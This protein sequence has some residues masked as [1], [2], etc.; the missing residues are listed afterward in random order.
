MPNAE[1]VLALAE[2]VMNLGRDAIVLNLRFMDMAVFRLRPEP[3]DTTLATDGRYLFYGPEHVLRRYMQNEAL[4]ARDYLHALLHCV[5]RH[6][7][8]DSLVD[9]RL[10][11]LA[12][13]IA[14]ESVIASLDLPRFEAGREADQRP[15]IDAL[16]D[17]LGLLTAEK[18]YRCFQDD[19]PPQLWDDL[20]RADDHTL[21]HRPR[22]RRGEQEGRPGGEDP[23]DAE[24]PGNGG[25][26]AGEREEGEDEKQPTPRGEAGEREAGDEPSPAPSEA[27][28]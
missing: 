18:L 25:Q 2:Q 4:P 11:D 21:W 6:P 17:R 14:V 16:S 13:D 24:S 5:F 23:E 1:R 12:A 26:Q 8:I 3:A 22:G 10:W 7:Y 19:P 15:V 28:I 20:F 27:G 9:R